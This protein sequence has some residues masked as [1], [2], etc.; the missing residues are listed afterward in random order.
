MLVK[1][2]HSRLI[3][4]G[5]VIFERDGKDYARWALPTGRAVTRPLNRKGNR[6]VEESPCWYV[7]LR[8]PATNKWREWRAYR[9]R[10][11]SQAM[12]IE[13]IRK[14][15]RGEVGLV[16]R[17]SAHGKTS[18][19]EHL[20]A[21][22]EHLED[23]GSTQDHVERTLARCR[24][25][26]K[27]M[28]AKVLGDIT[29]EGIDSALAALRRGGASVA[30]SNGY[31]RAVRTFCRWLVRTKRIAENPVADL[32][33]LKV[34]EADR[35]RRR[36]PLDDEELTLLLAAARRSPEPFMGLSGPDRAMLYLVAANTGLR[37]SELASLTPES[38]ELDADQPIVRC[39]AGYTKNGEEAE[40]PLRQDM[41]ATLREWLASKPSCESVWPGKWAKERRGAEMIRIDM[42]AADLDCEDDRGRVADFHALRHT[43]ISNL[44]RAGVHPRNAQ[45]LARH[46]TIDLTMNVYT[47]VSMN[48]LGRD[49]ESLPALDMAKGDTAAESW[50]AATEESVAETAQPVPATS[51]SA[52]LSNLASNWDSL[53]DHIRNVI[54]SLAR[55]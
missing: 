17:A 28:E 11:A 30:T 52:E 18:I 42:T 49:V 19:D 51:V 26:V 4:E 6:V 46:S 40:L 5:A 41:V 54:V 2:R 33:C 21:F 9:D 47:H 50:A 32:T 16:G 39:R 44:A 36:R 29:A 24:W 27:N 23:K 3:P 55:A 38:F 25:L 15:E 34:S 13:I 14:I 31:H 48:D 45:A 10:Q 53:P 1:R 43:F 7:R 37:A 22:E 20:R 35:R 8:H 12:E